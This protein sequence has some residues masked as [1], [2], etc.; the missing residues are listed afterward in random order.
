MAGGPRLGLRL[1]GGYRG[2]TGLRCLSNKDF[3]GLELIRPVLLNLQ[4]SLDLPSGPV[5]SWVGFSE[6]ES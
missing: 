1:P 2:Y 3:L 5:L 4:V 6:P